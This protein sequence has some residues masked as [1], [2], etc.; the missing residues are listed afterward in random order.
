MSLLPAGIPVYESMVDGAWMALFIGIF[1]SSMV[2]G[3]AAV[4]WLMTMNSV[5]C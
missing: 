1:D 2:C 3:A 5:G 4:P